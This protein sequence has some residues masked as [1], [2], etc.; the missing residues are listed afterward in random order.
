MKVYQ[1]IKRFFRLHFS[2]VKRSF[3]IKNVKNAV[4]WTYGDLTPE[5]IVREFYEKEL[6][7]R[8]KSL[9]WKN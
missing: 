2:L 8:S 1:N 5:E 3:A 9:K 4:R 7:N 6:K